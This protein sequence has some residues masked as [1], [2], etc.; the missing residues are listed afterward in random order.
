MFEYPTSLYVLI[1]VIFVIF[2]LYWLATGNSCKSVMLEGLNEVQGVYCPSCDDLS[3]NKCITCY[4]CGFKADGYSGK[5]V[6]GEFSRPYTKEDKWRALAVRTRTPDKFV[7]SFTTN[8]R[9]I[10]NDTFWRNLY[11]TASP[12]DY[13]SDAFVEKRSSCK[14][15]NELNPYPPETYIIERNTG[16]PIN[17]TGYGKRNRDCVF[18]AFE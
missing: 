5:C 1:L 14:N 12:A 3:F 17:V 16:T 13:S 7:K 9:W 8:D 10:P 6:P 2:Y 11:R 15:V 4:N 18:P